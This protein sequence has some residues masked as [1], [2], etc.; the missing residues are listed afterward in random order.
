MTPFR[1]PQIRYKPHTRPI[2]KKRPQ[3]SPVYTLHTKPPKNYS[4]QTS[5]PLYLQTHLYKQTSKN[6][7]LDPQI[8]PLP[9]LFPDPLNNVTNLY[10]Q[11]H[12]LLEESKLPEL[13][14]L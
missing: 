2:N 1:R 10:K 4:P 3:P 5:L 9:Y 14:G 13:G 8:I 12:T 6:C 11:D 7:T